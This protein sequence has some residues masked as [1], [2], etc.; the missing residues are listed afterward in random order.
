VAWQLG[1]D[2]KVLEAL[3]ASQVETCDQMMY[4]NTEGSLWI[5]RVSVPITDIQRARLGGVALVRNSLYPGHAVSW[6]FEKPANDQ[7]VAILIPDATRTSFK[8]IA[9]NLEQR[10]VN[11]TMTGWNVDPGMWE[12]TQGVDANGDDAA[13][14]TPA[15]KEVKLERSGTVGVTFPPR[16]TTVLTFKLKTPGTPYWRRADVGIG[17][18]DVRVEGGQ[19][20]VTVHSLGTVD[21]AASTVRVLDGAGKELGRAAVPAMK[22]VTDLTPV[23]TE[24]AVALPAGAAA[25]S[26]V[27]D[28]PAE[29][30]T[31]R[32]NRVVLEG[33]K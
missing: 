2:K 32:N 31:Q 24:V 12:M 5:D 19:V 9:Y 16:A 15:G 25:A 27:L 13:D 17:A 18:E 22:G 33:A 30:I 23:R 10:A 7:S 3:Y 6:E 21:A 4:I 20:R 28:G 29:E 26:V 8:V 1:G 11:A 14:G